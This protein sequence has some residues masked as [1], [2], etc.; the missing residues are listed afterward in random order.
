[1]GTPNAPATSRVVV[2]ASGSGSNLQAILDACTSSQLH[3]EAV[4]VVSDRPDVCAYHLAR[5]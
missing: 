2:L 3:A 1:M 5:P 4:A